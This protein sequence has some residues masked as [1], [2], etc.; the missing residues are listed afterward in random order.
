[1]AS[2]E[3][4]ASSPTVE[5]GGIMIVS[6]RAYD[7]AHK[8]L[9]GRTASW[10]SSNPAV[11]TVNN[12]TVTGV[13]PG[14]ASIT[15]T[16]DG[17][18]ASVNVTVVAAPVASIVFTP[19]VPAVRQGETLALTAQPV[20]A[21]G[22]PLSGRPVTWSTANA[23]I[24]TVNTTTGVVTGVSPGS[25]YIRAEA[26][27]KR[28]SVQLRVKS[29]NAPAITG[30]SQAQLVPGAT[31]TITGTNFGA[32]PNDNQV[33]VN[34]AAA[35]ITAA[36]TT[37]ISFTVP[38]VTALPCTATGPAQ[39]MLVANAD[40]AIAAMSLAMATPRALAV[41]Q[42]MLLTSEADLRCNEFSTT[43]GKYLF[44]AFNYATSAG[45]M[46]SF[47]LLGASTS[48]VA[49]AMAA[50]SAPVTSAAAALA[51]SS[52]DEARMARHLRAHLALQRQEREMAR[53]MGNPRLLQRMRRSRDNQ[54][55]LNM[56]VS[57][58][59]ALGSTATYRMRR[60]FDNSGTYDDVTFRA[61]YVGS[62]IILYE[63]AS[64]PLA[65]TMD[66]EYQR[67]GQEF[68]NVMFP[69]LQAFGNPLVVDSALDNNGHLIALFSPRVN[70][71]R[72]NG[73]SNAILGYVTL[74][75]Y[76]PRVPTVV[77]GVTIPA[78]PSSNEAEAFYAIVPNPTAT[79]GAISIA[80]WRQF[81]RGTLIHEAKHITSY[82]ERY[83]RD[84]EEIEDVWLEEATAQQAS[85]M[86]ARLLY[87]KPQFGDIGWDD[88]PRCD[89]A[90]PGGACPDPAEGILH[91][92]SFLYEH[93]NALESKSI[94]DDP[95]GIDPVIY[96]SSWSFARWVT[97]QFPDE[98]TFLRSI[99]Q[100]KNDH[101]VANVVAKSGMP[102]SQLLGFWSLASLA[103]NYP[104]AVINDN[105][106][107]LPSWNS[108]DLFAQ[109]SAELIFSNGAPAFPRPWPMNV[110][111]VSFGTFQAGSSDV[112]ALPGGG[113][114]AWELAGVQSAP[115]VLAVRALDGGQPPSLIGLA[116]VRIQ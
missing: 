29:L 64:A 23:G 44:T 72:I 26:E 50:T 84:A 20:D 18:S 65:N 108:R 67:I 32:L 103:D 30:T 66:Q 74:C 33:F 61:V 6:A 99:V 81:I 25:V 45:V 28:D 96:G 36:S 89:Y 47:K 73:V 75:D 39:I 31:G 105:R 48:G 24:A 62:K 9:A 95:E 38:S 15:A 34:G 53:R 16:I 114:A 4:T 93:Y 52:P 111:Q 35:A 94:L 76:F 92:F 58:P 3:V 10:Q 41:G 54:A 110:R 21:V 80:A 8:P 112:T 43:G 85:E 88:G 46:T 63:D 90:R 86:W 78:C 5:V 27:G 104:G 97:D 49:A 13:T 11:A 7:A 113:F 69:L 98:A 51:A 1:V 2:V 59:P 116:I 106:L 109:M 42:S 19:A 107:K 115:Q 87:S 79:S 40:T 22:R 68:D 102:F 14:A 71:Y 12:G 60:T 83:Y 57:P 37:S 82:A 101:G 56:A 77:G 91:H 100:V 17:K 70:N 55:L